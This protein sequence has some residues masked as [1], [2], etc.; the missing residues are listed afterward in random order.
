[1]ANPKVLIVD[2]DAD[3]ALGIGIRLQRSGYDV[4]TAPD[5]VLAQQRLL[6]DRPYAVILDLGLPGG[7]GM[8]FLR[9]AK[10]NL[11]T[12]QIPV[13]VLTAKDHSVEAEVLAAGAAE[14]HQKPVDNE[15]L[16]EAI[17]RALGREEANV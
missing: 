3:L 5:A 11:E 15:T 9:R 16:I 14:F 8:T 17:E 4:A 2:D 13:I 10:A 7:G 1:M 6:R 12:T